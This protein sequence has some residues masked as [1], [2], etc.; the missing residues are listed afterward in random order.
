[1]LAGFLSGSEYET[2]ENISM[3]PYSMGITNDPIKYLY[4]SKFVILIL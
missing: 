2:R 4:I 3:S 1:M